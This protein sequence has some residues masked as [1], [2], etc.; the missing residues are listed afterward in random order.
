MI[1]GSLPD[2]VFIGALIAICI[3]PQIDLLSQIFASNM[4]DFVKYGVYTCR[5]YVEGEWVDVVTDTFIPCLTDTLTNVS[6]PVYS[7]SPNPTEMWI[8]LAEKAYAKANGS[9]EAIQNVQVYE[10]L[11]H[12]TGGSVQ[13]IDIAEN[14][15]SNDLNFIWLTIS[16]HVDD[17]TIIL[18]TSKDQV[19]SEPLEKSEDH[20]ISTI[21]IQNEDNF[22]C[23]RMYSITCSFNYKETKLLLLHNPWSIDPLCD[24][25][26]GIYSNY[27]QWDSVMLEKA[28][29]A[30]SMKQI[31]WTLKNPNKYFWIPFNDFHKYFK[32]I[33]FCKLFPENY[34]Y[35]C[36]RDEWK[37]KVSGGPLTTIRDSAIALEDAMKAKKDSFQKAYFANVIDGDTSW[38]NNPQYRIQSDY[39]DIIIFISCSSLSVDKDGGHIPTGLDI[40][41]T[42]RIDKYGNDISAQYPII[43]D[44]VT[45]NIIANEKISN[46]KCKGNESSIW[47]LNLN[48]QYTYHIIP[49]T[50]RRRLDGEFLLRVFA[51]N[52]VLIEKIPNLYVTSIRGD[53]H[54]SHD[55]DSTGGPRFL[56]HDSKNLENPKW[57]Q[58]P[59]FHLTL[60]DVKAKTLVTLKI[61]IKRV[62]KHSTSSNMHSSSM[63]NTSIGS[64]NQSTRKAHALENVTIG[65]TI[66]RPSSHEETIPKSYKSKTEPKTNALGQVI[67]MKKFSTLKKSNEILENITHEEEKEFKVMRKISIHSNETNVYETTN[68]SKSESVILLSHIPREL[69]KEGLLIIPCLSEKGVKGLFELEVYSSE[70]IKLYQL[71]DSFN[72]SIASEWKESNAMGSHLNP[73]W[74]KNPKFSLVLQSSKDSN[75]IEQETSVL[76]RITLGRYGLNWKSMIRKDKVGSM[77]GF[78]IFHQQDGDMKL[79]YET[80]F[81]LADEISTDSTFSLPILSKHQGEYIILPAT[82]GENKIGSFIL[83]VMTSVEFKLHKAG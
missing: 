36:I 1:Q 20:S 28:E 22:I 27:Y 4:D 12:L 47:S 43:W 39:N 83:S 71:P 19:L 24:C 40:I 67:G 31:S 46:M 10:A 45:A 9:Y 61:V 17:C 35:Y 74:K 44:G 55:V 49:H 7:R 23:N 78:Y 62:D 37:D 3:F 82:Y 52:K 33:H 77:F 79:I 81:V 29:Y 2:E 68:F 57:C 58:N 69:I 72:R 26:K 15:L 64:M 65:L 48:K 50:L 73:N 56:K 11:I 30:C 51:S 5:F 63:M 59:Q 34:R 14:I 70:R 41:T 21:S 32:N 38:F 13:H 6:T 54:R 42:P 66:C 60:E 18:A 76:I 75:S 53:W 80:P 25:W 16:K 8:S